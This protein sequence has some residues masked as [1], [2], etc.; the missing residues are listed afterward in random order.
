MFGQTVE[1][2]E[3]HQIIDDMIVLEA[4]CCVYA[5]TFW[6]ASL[7]IRRAPCPKLARALKTCWIGLLTA[8]P[9]GRMISARF[10]RQCQISAKKRRAKFGHQFL[11]GIAFIAPF[12]P[13][14]G[15]DDPAFGTVIET[16]DAR[17][18]RTFE[19]SSL[20]LPS[21]FLQIR[22]SKESNVS[23]GT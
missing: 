22:E 1:R 18:L 2:S 17:N 19:S 6:R 21:M 3:V 20:G 12:L 14:K 23:T 11:A 10:R 8:R 9:L 5:F 15:E 7:G 4:D 13:P 16:V